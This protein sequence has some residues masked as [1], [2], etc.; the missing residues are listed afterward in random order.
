MPEGKPGKLSK[1]ERIAAAPEASRN[2]VKRQIEALTV[3]FLRAE[4][5]WDQFLLDL[6]DWNPGEE[7][8]D[9]TIAIHRV[10]NTKST[11]LSG[12]LSLHL[13]LL[14][15]VVERWKM[16][17]YHH[18][19]VDVLL[20]SPNLEHLKRFRHVIFH[21]DSLEATTRSVLFTEQEPARWC[22]QLATAFEVALRVAG[23]LRPEV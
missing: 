12:M 17:A 15:A 13:A 8:P 1:A 4:A 2:R 23:Q 19:L 18:D 16:W 20:E 10:R 7:E 14:Y 5:M 9:A 22:R 11:R 6:R 21:A 3:A